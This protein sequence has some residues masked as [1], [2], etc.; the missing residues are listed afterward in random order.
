MTRSPLPWRLQRARADRRT[1]CS[2]PAA[3]TSLLGRSAQG[4]WYGANSAMRWAMVASRRQRSESRRCPGDRQWHGT[5]ARG[6]RPPND[7]PSRSSDLIPSSDLDITVMYRCRSS[8]SGLPVN[9][10]C[11]PALPAN[12][13]KPVMSTVRPLDTASALS[14]QVDS[15][16]RYNGPPSSLVKPSSPTC[17]DTANGRSAVRRD[18][19]L[20]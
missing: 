15:D 1:L 8:V 7:S 3:S 19:M 2:P 17:L 20:L 11:S 9:V 6:H 18:A 10:D 4:C 14:G 16:H 5:P 13:V 12:A